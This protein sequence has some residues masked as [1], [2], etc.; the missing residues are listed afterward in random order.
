[1]DDDTLK[2]K[3]ANFLLDIQA[4]KAIISPKN[5]IRNGYNKII[6]PK[7]EFLESIKDSLKKACKM[8]ASFTQIQSALKKNFERDISIST[9]KRFCVSKGYYVPKSKKK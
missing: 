1:M 7:N 9:L 3:Q 2:Q 8:K 6:S 4:S 5:A